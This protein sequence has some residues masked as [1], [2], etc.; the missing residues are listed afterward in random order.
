MKLARTNVRTA[1]G[2]CE[3]YSKLEGICSIQSR[4]SGVMRG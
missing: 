3:E 2:N 4:N 1:I